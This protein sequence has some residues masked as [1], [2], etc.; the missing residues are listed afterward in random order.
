M[1]LR[2]LYYSV[3]DS[4]PGF[5][6]RFLRSAIKIQNTLKNLFKTSIVSKNFNGKKLK[7]NVEKDLNLFLI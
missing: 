2:L 5:L 1:S 6:D 3:D 4:N 7:F